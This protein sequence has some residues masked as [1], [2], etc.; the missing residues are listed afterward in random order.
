[1]GLDIGLRIG[2]PLQAIWRRLRGI[3]AHAA[4]AIYGGM[5]RGLNYH[6]RNTINQEDQTST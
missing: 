6:E 4:N 3:Q 2:M 1:M 5:A